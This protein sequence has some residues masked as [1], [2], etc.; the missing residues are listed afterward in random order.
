M[1]RRLR[2]KGLPLDGF[3]A[4]SVVSASN[5]YVHVSLHVADFR[6]MPTERF[7]SL[8]PDKKLVLLVQTVYGQAD[9]VLGYKNK[10]N[11]D[12][13]RYPK[14][15]VKPQ[16]MYMYMY[17]MAFKLEMMLGSCSITVI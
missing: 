9:I 5:M 8:I 10:C 15:H 17:F 11:L 13:I 12:I 16:Y 6:L 1:G 4:A 14:V 7:F 2:R 3:T